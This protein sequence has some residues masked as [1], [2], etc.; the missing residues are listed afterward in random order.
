ML[1]GRYVLFLEDERRRLLLLVERYHEDNQ[2][3]VDRLLMKAEVPETTKAAFE[4]EVGKIKS[5]SDLFEYE[6]QK[7]D[8]KAN[9]EDLEDNRKE[10]D[11]LV[12]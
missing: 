11:T 1:K 5:L 8:D 10:Q 12:N 4:K 7:E 9:A 2:R 6:G 3:L